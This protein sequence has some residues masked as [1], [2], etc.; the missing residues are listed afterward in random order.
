M[1]GRIMAH[2]DGP[3]FTFR[4][5]EPGYMLLYMAKGNEGCGQN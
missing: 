3:F 5:L 1:V 2:E 4:N